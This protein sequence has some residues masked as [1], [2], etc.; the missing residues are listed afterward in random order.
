MVAGIFQ[1]LTWQNSKLATLNVPPVIK[2]FPPLRKRWVLRKQHDA[3]GV[4]DGTEQRG[5]GPPL[6]GGLTD[7][8]FGKQHLK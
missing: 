5:W 6:D 2:K 3:D 4:S 8:L 7:G 1:S